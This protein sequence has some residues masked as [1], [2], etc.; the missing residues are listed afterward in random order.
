MSARS[1][2]LM[3]LHQP[4]RMA[5][6]AI[7]RGI[8]KNESGSIPRFCGPM[9]SHASTKAAGRRKNAMRQVWRFT[10]GLATLLAVL[11]MWIA[12][13][14]LAQEPSAYHGAMKVQGF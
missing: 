5:F 11:G 10:E 1:P 2:A 9:V 3:R 6:G 8:D 12:N 14:L 13:P 7:S 4:G